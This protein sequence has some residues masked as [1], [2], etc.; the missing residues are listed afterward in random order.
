MRKSAV[1]VFVAVIVAALTLAVVACAAP[2][3]AAGEPTTKV[4]WNCRNISGVTT[5]SWQECGVATSEPGKLSLWAT[6]AVGREKVFHLLLVA[7][8]TVTFQKLTN[9]GNGDPLSE[10]VGQ[11][12]FRKE[13]VE[14]SKLQSLPPEIQEQFRGMYDIPV[15]APE[16]V[17]EE[18]AAA[19]DQ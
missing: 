4:K 8:G 11:D 10:S 17:P 18:V 2:T 15:S 16:P 7:N 1:V 3:A 9:V 13:C 6:G 19:P 5:C 12:I 14:G